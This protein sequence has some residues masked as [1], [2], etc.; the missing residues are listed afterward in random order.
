MALFNRS[1]YWKHVSPTGM[2]ADFR[3]VWKEAGQNRWRIAAVSAACTFSVFY[4]M[5][6]QEARGPHPPPKVTYI[7]VL[8]AH[9]TDAQIMA[10]NVENQ[11][12]KEAWAAELARRDK[13]VR[14]MYKT[15]GRMSGMDVDKIAHD[16]EVEEAARKKAELEEIGAPRLPEGRSLPQIDQQPAREPA[17]Q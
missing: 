9:R 4:L 1:G 17:E 2:V 13:D 12:R 14:E 7:S 11:K 15:I 5:S 10:S 8:P 16:A 6:T 3:A